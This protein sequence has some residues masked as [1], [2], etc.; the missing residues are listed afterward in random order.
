MHKGVLL[1][2]AALTLVL[3]YETIIYQKQKAFLL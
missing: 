2:M 1:L 3:L